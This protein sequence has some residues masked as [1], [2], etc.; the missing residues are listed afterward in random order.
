VKMRHSFVTALVLCL[1][2]PIAAQSANSNS[3]PE[4]A[5]VP[6]FIK[7]SATLSTAASDASSPGVVLTPGAAPT[8][9][10]AVTFSLYTEQTGGTAL[11]SE[12]QNVRV[13]ASGH[14]TVQLGASKPDGLPMDIF[15]A[16]QAK[17]LG[18]QSQGQAEQPRVMLMSVP[19]ALKAA[20]AETF[21]GL[22]PSAYALTPSTDTNP[23]AGNGAI[24]AGT[25]NRG[26]NS[27]KPGVY[28]VTG[29]G[30]TGYIPLWS[31]FTSLKSSALYQSPANGYL[32]IGTT[33]PIA[34]LDVVNNNNALALSGTTSSSALP[35]LAGVNNATSGTAIAV[36]G[37]THSTGGVSVLGHAVAATGN[38][39]GVEGQSDSTSG[40]GVLGVVTANSGS[41]VGAFGQT[42][43]PNG[44]GVVGNS[45]SPTGPSNGVEGL[46]NGPDAIAVLGYNQSTTGQATG[47]EGQSDSP[48]GVGVFGVATAVSGNVMGVAG[49]TSSP[50]GFGVY[51]ANAA[52]SGSAY[53]VGGSSVSGDPNASGVYGQAL[54]S[55]GNTNGVY[56]VTNSTSGDADGV[57]GKALSTSGGAN[58]VTGSTNAP[59]GYGV[60]GI[61]ASTDPSGLSYGVY[62]QSG[63]GSGV[64]G[65]TTGN[66][67]NSQF[68]DGGVI[69]V[70]E[71]NGQVFSQ[72]VAG[73][74]LT[75]TGHSN[76]VYGQASSPA[77]AAGIFDNSAG[78]YILFGRVNGG[79]DLFHVDGSGGGHFAGAVQIDSGGSNIAG[80][81]TIAGDLNVNGNLNKLSGSFK[82]DDPLDPANKYLSHSFV[83]SPDM[84]NIY[85]GVVRLDARGE[86]WVVLPA[87]F[88]ALNRDFRYQL[89]SLGVPQPR[90]YIAR[91]VN[92]NRFKIS[93]G[94]ANGK[95]SWQVTGVRQDAWANAH[96]IP[97]EEDKPLEKRGT[98]LY[99]EALR[100]KS[101]ENTNAMLQH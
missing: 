69:G 71:T 52:T 10:V 100:D 29:N 34:S 1:S 43:S 90:L 8:Q 79:P 48:A 74:N 17:W 65:I 99:P 73:I 92:G 42:N 95:V 72:G 51:G 16:A 61:A 98:Y 26:P 31:T 67:G 50:T 20:D 68:S 86:S 13:D 11:W 63:I 7:F 84:M 59:N 96:R 37:L 62:G 87:Y 93:G 49:N 4:S 19:Y 82:I 12:I 56:G 24:T 101:K 78:G 94:R 57:F 18:V 75:A 36:E 30:N 45:L 9:V 38:S 97:N 14:Y 40:T 39:L 44:K 6:R 55:T 32:G 2:L 76:G 58:G 23:P 27:S 81:V 35:A 80:T 28:Y 91:E 41:T 25:G 5:P 21:G 22:P 60:W 64:V 54:S 77:G 3:A 53:G 88:E 89:T 15:A 46:A 85:N 33:T 83:E 47:V 66:N 70:A